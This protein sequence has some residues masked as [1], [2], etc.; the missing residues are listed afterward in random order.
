MPDLET[1]IW[2]RFAGDDVLVYGLYADET[3]EQVAD[4]VDQTG[5]TFPVLFGNYTLVSFA[6]PLDGYPFPRQVLIGRDR[7]VRALK[8]DLDIAELTGQIEALLAEGP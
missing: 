2:Q 8:S 5:I 1:A 6:F 7:T 4:F 3:P